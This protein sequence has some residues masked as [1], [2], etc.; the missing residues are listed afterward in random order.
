MV[1]SAEW[2]TPRPELASGGVAE[3]PQIIESLRRRERML[4]ASA[5]GSHLLLQAPDV[6]AVVPEVLR[7]I[8]EA[9][10][11]D[12]VNIML[13]QHGPAGERLLVVAGEW[14]AEG[15]QPRLGDPEMNCCNESDYAH[16]AALLRAGQSVSIHRPEGP[17]HD[18][19]GR[20][21][22]AGTKS[23]A[24][25]PIFID[26]E[27]IGVAGFDNVRQRR[28]IDGA[29]MSALETAAGVIGAALHRERLVDAVRREREQAAE[30]RVA[31]L[32]KANAAIRS[33]L[34]RL[35]NTPDLANYMS[36]MLVEV[37]RQLDAASGSV[38][39]L[40]DAAGQWR[41]VT[42][43]KDGEPQVPDFAT[44]VAC[45]EARF[46]E[47]LRRTREPMYL[48][49]DDR[50]DAELVW[51]G[52]LETKRANGYVSMYVTPLV[53]GN[54]TVGCIGLAFRRRDP[55]GP[56]T[57]E[58]LV[59]LAQ[60]ATLAIE[61]TRLA[62]SEKAAA[63]LLERNRIGQEIHDGLAQAFTGILM[64]LAAVEEST[65][66]TRGAMRTT[67]D[68]I[69]DLARD[70][71]TEAR[72]SV[73]ALRPDQTRRG[74]LGVALEQLAE[75]STVRGGVTISYEGSGTATGLAPEHEHELF[76]IAQEAVS[77][78]VRHAKPSAVRILLTEE[79]GY[80][81]LA[82]QDNGCGMRSQPAR[83]AQQGFGLV[84]MQE[85]A[86]AIGGDW[87]IETERGAGTTVSVRVP[88]RVVA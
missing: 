8:G 86:S 28:A 71:L 4:A 7:L 52:T 30:A 75:R 19:S 9:A 47:K 37:T 33:N 41:V 85:R 44:T 50:A 87:A 42:Y 55:I 67:V 57:G 15:V 29:E 49:L 26:G 64:Q 1:T 31:A 72:R 36:S 80:W 16:E 20:F 70:G 79:S 17:G 60:Q 3:L 59:A 43:V 22:G 54:R 10:G 12:R 13:A 23:K 38:I 27:F 46:D 11:V 81:R 63:V 40:D 62:D 58:M 82:I 66:C 74:G 14:V 48:D 88:K 73:M 83:H 69:R 51:P 18:C 24:I 84:S 53:F 56:Q 21:E 77:N 65:A 45:A 35:A 68:R 76:R 78:A 32:A 25:V 2:I 6:M 5:R 39:V 61:L 34:E